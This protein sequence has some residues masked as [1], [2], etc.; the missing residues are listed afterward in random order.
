MSDAQ[1]KGR[2]RAVRSS[3]EGGGANTLTTTPGEGDGITYGVGRCHSHM[4]NS[5]QSPLMALICHR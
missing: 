5:L 4:R 1:R 2:V 3:A